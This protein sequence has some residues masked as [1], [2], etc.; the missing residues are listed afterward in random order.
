MKS[1]DDLTCPAGA[2]PGTAFCFIFALMTTTRNPPSG[3]SLNL[4]PR[5]SLPPSHRSK[6][7]SQQTILIQETC[8]SDLCETT[9]KSQ[10]VRRKWSKN[11]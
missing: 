10:P 7:S 5:R 1:R 6:L 3:K 4:S 9:L 11:R 2:L 8:V